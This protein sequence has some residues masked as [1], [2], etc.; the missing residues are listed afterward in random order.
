LPVM[1]IRFTPIT[2]SVPRKVAFQ[3][4]IEGPRESAEST[5]CAKCFA[6]RQ[7]HYAVAPFSFLFPML[8]LSVFRRQ[9]NACAATV[10]LRDYPDFLATG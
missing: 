5:N 10:C 2:I 4:L 9:E 3:V 8:D 1:F 6:Q 7:R